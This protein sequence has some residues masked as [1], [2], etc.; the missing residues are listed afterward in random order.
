MRRQMTSQTSRSLPAGVDDQ[1]PCTAGLDMKAARTMAGFTPVL[2]SHSGRR[3]KVQPSMRTGGESTNVVGVAIQA[4]TI[5][6]INCS[7]DLLR[8]HDRT[9]GARTRLKNQ[10]KQNAP[11]AYRRR[12]KGATHD[13][14]FL[15]KQRLSM[16][17]SG[18]E[19]KGMSLPVKFRL[20]R[21]KQAEEN[22][23]SL[24]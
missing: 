20:I 16:Q 22:A 24:L 4:G 19:A 5:A 7:G 14:N 21:V 17:E 10:R 13:A 8:H 9:G 23:G 15:G 3:R 6:D 2:P 18:A 1:P 12:K 11:D